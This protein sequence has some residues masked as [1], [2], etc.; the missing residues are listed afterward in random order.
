MVLVSKKEQPQGF[1]RIGSLYM[2]ERRVLAPR[3][4]VRF[5]LARPYIGGVAP[6][7]KS[8]S[9]SRSSGATSPYTSSNLTISSTGSNYALVAWVCSTKVLTGAALT[10]NGVSMTLIGSQSD[11]A[12]FYLYLFGLVNPASGAQTLSLSWTSGGSPQIYLAA[13]SFTGVNQTGGTASFANFASASGTNNAPTLTVTSATGNMVVASF[14]DSNGTI[15]GG[16][17]LWNDQANYPDWSGAYAS[18]AASVTVSSG[19]EGDTD[20]CAIGASL[21][22]ATAAVIVAPRL[23][24]YLRR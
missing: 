5:P 1:R 8:S 20:W 16:T 6:D 21:V 3:P 13:A 2:P 7:A 24:T 14:T 18:G 12:G 4:G 10:W 15:T 23:K 9:V 17:L 22:A 11:A 19:N